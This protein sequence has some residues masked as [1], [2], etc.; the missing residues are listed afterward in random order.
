MTNAEF[1]R[2]GLFSIRHS[3]ECMSGKEKPACGQRKTDAE[4]RPLNKIAPTW[5]KEFDTFWAAYP[6]RIAKLDAQKAYQQV[7]KLASPDEILA[8]VQRYIESKP[9]WQAW[10]H[11]AA[12]LRAGRWMDEH[13]DAKASRPS[14]YWAD[15]CKEMHG[16]TCLKQWDH[17]MKKLAARQQSQ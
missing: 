8:G 5:N 3:S 11:P 12:W 15:E 6:H 17:E 10:K 2:V 9:G 4:F 7:R 13:E 1:R 16:G 14:V